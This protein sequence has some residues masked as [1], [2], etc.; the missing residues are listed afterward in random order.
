MIDELSH[1]TAQ[2][3]V[4]GEFALF[5]HPRRAGAGAR[6]RV[7]PW[8]LSGRRDHEPAGGADKTP[9]REKVDAIGYGFLGTDQLASCLGN[10][11][12]KID[13]RHATVRR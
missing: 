13:N 11:S 7:G 5:G 10:A 4:R 9:L 2:L 12:S 8:R 6:G 1:A 3:R